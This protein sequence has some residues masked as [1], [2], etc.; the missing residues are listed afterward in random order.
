MED[1]LRVGSGLSGLL[2][3]KALGGHDFDVRLDYAGEA[4]GV[5]S[6]AGNAAIE[7]MAKREG[8]LLDPVY[9]GKAFAGLVEMARARE[10]S[11]KVLFW[12]TGGVPT[13]FAMG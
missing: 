8:I 4:Y 1:V 5:P 3:V 7:Y 9:T 12:H 10:L 2:R 6:E 13:I 11:G